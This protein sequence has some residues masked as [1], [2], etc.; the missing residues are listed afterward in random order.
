MEQIIVE[1]KTINTTFPSV[2][3]VI[4]NNEMVGYICENKEESRVM[5]KQSIVLLDGTLL[6]DYCCVEHAVKALT[7]HHCG[8]DGIYV[9]SKDTAGLGALG[10]LLIAS[11]LASK[12]KS[13][14]EAG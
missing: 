8:N 5:K 4:I 13:P 14:H 12:E 2:A 7:K 11:L 9:S 1:L 3:E 10:I 6:G